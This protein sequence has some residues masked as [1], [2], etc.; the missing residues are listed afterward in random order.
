MVPVAETEMAPVPERV[1]R[2]KKICPVVVVIVLAE[3]VATM[4]NMNVGPTTWLMVVVAVCADEVGV[5]N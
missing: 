3:D 1:R 4:V 5:P 2:F